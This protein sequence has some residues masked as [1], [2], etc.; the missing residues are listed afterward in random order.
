MG[1]LECEDVGVEESEM[2]VVATADG[3]W[4]LFIEYLLY[5]YSRSG[6]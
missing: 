5:M 4:L 3:A 6:K 2:A 1:L